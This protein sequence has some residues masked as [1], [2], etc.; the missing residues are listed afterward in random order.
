MRLFLSSYLAGKYPEKLVELFG[1]GTSVAVI[2]NAKDY[3]TPEER[4]VKVDEVLQFL[5]ELG[6]KPVE[7]DLRKYFDGRGNPEKDLRKFRAFW[8]AGGNV[9]LLRRAIRQSQLEPLLGDWVRKNEVVLGGES[10]GAIIV[11]PTLRGAEDEWS[12]E[13]SPYFRAEGYEEEVIWE[14]LRYITYVPAPHYQNTNYG[15]VIEKYINDLDRLKIA[16]KTMTDDQA[17]IINGA[18]EEFLA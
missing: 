2:T 15:P 14:G 11:G 5:G 3:K 17:I 16:Y 10:A 18:K 13:D 1:R 12:A 8:L 6:L 7:I 4:K 9:F